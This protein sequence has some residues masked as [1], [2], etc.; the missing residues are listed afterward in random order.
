[1][2]SEIFLVCYRFNVLGVGDYRF[3]VSVKVA[4]QMKRCTKCT[5]S[6]E[7]LLHCNLIVILFD[8]IQFIITFMPGVP[9]QSIK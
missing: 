5:R 4:S 8:F 2:C 6:S 7:S 3:R 9:R 1:M